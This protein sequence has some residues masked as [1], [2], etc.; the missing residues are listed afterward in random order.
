MP[1][2]L[3][4]QGAPPIPIEITATSEADAP[5]LSL[6]PTEVPEQPARPR[7]MTLDDSPSYVSASNIA[8]HPR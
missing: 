4:D 3:K 5:R 1:D 8:I 2:E 7:T 6:Q